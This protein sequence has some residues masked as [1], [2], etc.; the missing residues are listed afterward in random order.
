M[1]GTGREAELER[2]LRRKPD[3]AGAADDEQRVGEQPRAREN[4]ETEGG[5]VFGHRGIR[6]AV[7]K[8]GCS[9]VRLIAGGPKITGSR[10]GT[11]PSAASA[12]LLLQQ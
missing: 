9:R 7:A 10:A 1:I 6:P 12:I 5:G 11:G 2:D 3:E 8:F 4:G